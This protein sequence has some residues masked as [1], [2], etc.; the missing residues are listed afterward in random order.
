MF[1]HRFSAVNYTNL[2][3]DEADHPVRATYS[4]QLNRS[5]S[6]VGKLES[7]Y[8]TVTSSKSEQS[9]R[10]APSRLLIIALSFTVLRISGGYYLIV[11]YCIS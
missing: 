11:V 5:Q 9:Y 3:L 4:N 10:Y 1:R 2:V 7:P 6:A 8:N